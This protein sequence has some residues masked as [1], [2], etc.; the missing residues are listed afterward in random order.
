VASKSID[1]RV[2]K[3]KE[4]NLPDGSS[5]R[6]RFDHLC[7][8]GCDE[9]VLF[10]LLVVAVNRT[11]LRRTIYEIYGVSRKRVDK[12]A[13]ELHRVSKQ[14][15]SVERFLGDYFK[16]TLI[17]SPRATAN[18]RAR[19]RLQM[20]VYETTPKLLRLLSQHLRS[21]NSWVS[22]NVGP[23]RYDTSRHWLVQL[24]EYVNSC[25]N[26]PHYKDV[27]ELLGHL[28]PA[29]DGTVTDERAL[30]AAFHRA[31]RYGYRKTHGS[32]S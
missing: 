26:S 4:R 18:L 22:K 8:C 20:M 28:S 30:R 7:Q 9:R 10:A 16:A 13:E 11:D 5:S 24:L 6:E 14:L 31:Q 15:E 19:A 12:L 27:A 1:E 2:Q 17:E 3:W 29:P 25:T 23:K 32:A 21:A